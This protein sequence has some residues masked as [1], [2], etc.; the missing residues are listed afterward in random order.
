MN[1][2]R[3]E[4]GGIS[5]A[6]PGQVQP[7][8]S[9]AYALRARCPGVHVTVGG[10]ALTQM[11]LRLKGELLEKALGPFHSAVVYEGEIALLAMARAI[12]R[13]EDPASGGPRHPGDQIEDMSPPGPDFDGLPL[14]RYLAPELVLPYDPTRGCYWGVC[15]FCHYGLA[16]VGT[17][18]TASARRGRARSPRAL[19]A[20]HGVRVFYFSQDVFSP[21]IATR[22]ARGIRERGARREVG[23]RHAPREGRSPRRAAPSWWPAGC[24][25]RPSASSGA[26]TTCCRSSTR[27]SRPR[28]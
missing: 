26:P 23:D 22:I 15:T 20:K 28:T 11:L 13:G 24:C 4:A 9:L 25:R 21:R 6:F 5:V 7:A 8:F 12:E 19:S 10:P 3:G 14:D 17:A 27:G 1:A 16:E 2:A 18:R